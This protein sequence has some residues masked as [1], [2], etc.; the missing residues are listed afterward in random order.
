MPYHRVLTTARKAAMPRPSLDQVTLVP[1][2]DDRRHSQELETLLSGPAPLLIGPD[3]KGMEIPRTMR[4]LLRVVAH[5]FAT[6]QA[7]IVT[8]ANRDLTTQQA[9]EILGVS[10]PTL[11]RLLEETHAI[12]FTKVGSHR[13]INIADLLAYRQREYHRQ[14]QAMTDLTRLGEEL[15]GYEAAEDE[16]A[17]TTPR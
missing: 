1:T 17:P 15:G 8:P 10:R 9:A 14:R 4:A 6:D 12:P 5:T 13:R 2:A 16:A 11:V 7:V 3:G